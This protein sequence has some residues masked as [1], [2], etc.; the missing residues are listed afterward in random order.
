MAFPENAEEVAMIV[1]A[2]AE[3]RVP[4]VPFGI[5]SSLEGHVNAAAGDEEG[6]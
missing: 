4:V 5:G 1:R 2:C 6:R 3:H